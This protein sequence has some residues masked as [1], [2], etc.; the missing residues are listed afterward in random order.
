MRRG[1]D[2]KKIKPWQRDLFILKTLLFFTFMAFLWIY[3][4]GWMYVEGQIA[5]VPVWPPPMS[6]IPTITLNGYHNPDYPKIGE[7]VV[8]KGSVCVIDGC[9]PCANCSISIMQDVDYTD[10]LIINGF[11]LNESGEIDFEYKNNPTWIKMIG[12]N[13]TLHY[14]IP[15]PNFWEVVS[16]L[17]EKWPL[18]IG[19]KIASLIGIISGLVS[20]SFF[21]KVVYRYLKEKRKTKLSIGG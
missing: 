13:A 9:I 7:I 10:K 15:K 6:I 8:F 11:L 3:T 14:R 2:L 12:Y 1:I 4:N 5:P 18:N 21:S 20:L 16:I 17:L 19:I